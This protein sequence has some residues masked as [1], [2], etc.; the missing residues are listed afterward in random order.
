MKKIVTV[1]VCAVISLSAAGCSYLGLDSSSQYIK[2]YDNEIIEENTNDTALTEAEDAEE[3]IVSIPFE[4]SQSSAVSSDYGNNSHTSNSGGSGWGL[5][6]VCHKNQ[7][8]HGVYCDNCYYDHVQELY[9]NGIS[10]TEL[11]MWANGYGEYDDD[12]VSWGW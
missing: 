6:S 5:C 11:E 12:N 4:G 8:T 1:I 9:N 7:A 2:N 10:Q 3:T